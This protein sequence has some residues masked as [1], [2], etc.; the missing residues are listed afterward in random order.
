MNQLKATLSLLQDVAAD[1]PAAGDGGGIGR[2]SGCRR[3]IF[4]RSPSNFT[5]RATFGPAPLGLRGLH[6][7]AIFMAIPA[8]AQPISNGGFEDGLPPGTAPAQW[9]ATGDFYHWT[10]PSK[11]HTGS[12]YAYFG[13]GADGITPLTHT[14]GSIE[15]AAVLPI[16]TGPPMLSFWLWIA[17]DEPSTPA[18]D[19]LYVEILRTSGSILATLAD[20]SNADATG[21]V[22]FLMPGYIQR[23]LS[24]ASFAGESIRIRFRGITDGS[25]KTIFRLDD[26]MLGFASV[27]PARVSFP[28]SFCAPENCWC[29]PTFFPEQGAYGTFT[30]ANSTVFM[31]PP[32]VSVGQGVIWILPNEGPE[33]WGTVALSGGP[34]I[35]IGQAAA[36]RPRLSNPKHIAGGAFQFTISGITNR[37]CV[38]QSSSNLTDWMPLATNAISNGILTYA[39]TP[40]QSTRFYRVLAMPP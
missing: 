39:D 19:H 14:S 21:P 8:A 18:R 16:D 25:F 5:K 20:Y 4:E 40:A 33:R 15:Q 27:C 32:W 37:T 28:G 34:A 9:V 10:N 6:L 12:Q 22:G 3:T 35:E 29:G 7:A 1:D 24:L 38:V 30:A 23:T 17:S 13:V 26:V 36:A 11:A 31:V 2:A